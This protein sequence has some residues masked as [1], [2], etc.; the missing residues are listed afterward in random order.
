[1]DIETG[2]TIA[3][4]AATAFAITLVHYPRDL[5]QDSD[6]FRQSAFGSGYD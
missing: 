2:G 3:V 4:T 5:R 6:D 1:M